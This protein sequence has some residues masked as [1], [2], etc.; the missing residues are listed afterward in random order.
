MGKIGA[1]RDYEQC[2]DEDIATTEEAKTDLDCKIASRHQEFNLKK[3][4]TCRQLFHTES[5]VSIIQNHLTFV[6]KQI[7]TCRCI[8]SSWKLRQIEPKILI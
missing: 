8:K 4:N 1:D 6:I 7:C 5:E 2:F 3:Q